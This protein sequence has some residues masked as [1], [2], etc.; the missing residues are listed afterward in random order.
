M[1]WAYV[2]MIV[3]PNL[4]IQTALNASVQNLLF[5]LRE[6]GLKGRGTETACFPQW[7]STLK[8]ESCKETQQSQE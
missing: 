5:A 2:Q 4:R 8:Q 1:R 3:S 7:I 6:S